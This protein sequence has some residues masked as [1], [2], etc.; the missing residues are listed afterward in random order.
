MDSMLPTSDR[1]G[2]VG[3]C[4]SG[5]FVFKAAGCY[6]GPYRLRRLDL[7]RELTHQTR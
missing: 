2:A 1:V 5:P 3:Y 6:P 7:R 4:M